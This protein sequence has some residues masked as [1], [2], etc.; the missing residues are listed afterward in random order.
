M[1]SMSLIF[2]GPGLTLPEGSAEIF[3]DVSDILSF[4]ESVPVDANI[5][6][7]PHNLG[8]EMKGIYC[9][10]HSTSIII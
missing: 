4:T 1:T 5:R 3:V 10:Y 9:M 7:T 2:I 8:N 6:F